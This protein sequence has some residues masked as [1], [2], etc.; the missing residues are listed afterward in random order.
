[1]ERFLGLFP[2]VRVEAGLLRR[3]LEPTFPL[4]YLSLLLCRH[5]FVR[6]VVLLSPLALLLERGR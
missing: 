6:V 5:F 4:F 2:A 3:S 1:M